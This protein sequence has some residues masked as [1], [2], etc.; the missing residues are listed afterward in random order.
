MPFKSEAQ[1]RLFWAKVGRGEIS[2]DTAK[3]W[4]DATP[5]GKLPERVKQSKEKEGTMLKTA[6]IF[7]ASTPEDVIA[8]TTIPYRHRAAAYKEYL[9]QKSEE[10]PTPWG[11]ALLGGGAIGA[12]LG[13]LVGAS[14]GLRGA[15]LGALIGGLG[16]AG[17]G[18]LARAHDVGNIERAQNVLRGGDIDADLASQIGHVESRR[19]LDDY[20]TRERR[21]REM[22]GTI[23]GLKT[24]ALSE[25]GKVE[26]EHA[27][28]IRRLMA[29]SGAS[30]EEA[31]N[32]IANDHEKEL[33]RDYYPALKGMEAALEQTKKAAF[34]DEMGKIAAS[35]KGVLKKL[36]KATKPSAIEGELG[37]GTVPEEL[38]TGA[39]DKLKKLI[40]K[41][42]GPEAMHGEHR[43]VS[44]PE[45]LQKTGSAEELTTG[46][47]IRK[48]GPL[49][50]G[51][52]G[53]GLGLHSG[54]RSGNVLAKTLGG[55]AAGTTAG[56]VP[57]IIA[58]GVEGIRGRA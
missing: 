52:A 17:L 48:V 7:G 2:R 25:G 43:L 35:G 10:D 20:L 24:A 46:E 56:W 53:A 49:L 45:I 41:P 13:G 34:W 50:G 22:V 21:H 8:T 11:H 14:G 57:D 55:A 47:R 3:E 39:L 31:A 30:V 1:R 40:S 37:K 32:M 36:L 5:G 18:A 28:T 44:I 23:G 4:E 27:D 12:G 42:V 15:G 9:Q 6:R 51:L 19:R 38:R 29:N 58:S 26:M 54:L 16:G 33:G